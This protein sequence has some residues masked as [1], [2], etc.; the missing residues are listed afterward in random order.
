MIEKAGVAMVKTKPYRLKWKNNL[1]FLLSLI[2]YSVGLGNIWRFPYLCALN[3]GAVFLIPYAIF[4]FLVAFPLSFLELSIGQFSGKS[5]YD[6]WDI[7]PAFRGLGVAM[8]VVTG[9]LCLYYTMILAWILYYLFHSFMSPLPWTTCGNWWNTDTCFVHQY[10]TDNFTSTGGNHTNNLTS[11]LRNL[12][13]YA[14]NYSSL[15]NTNVSSTHVNISTIGLTAPE[16]FWNYNV[17]RM[18]TGLD[19]LGSMQWQLVVPLIISWIIIFLCIIKGVKSAGKVVYLT[20]IAPYIIITIILIRAATLPGAIDGVK[21]YIIPDFSKLANP[22]MWVQALMQIFYSAGMGWGG[23]ITMSSYNKFD[24]NVMRDTIIFCIVGEGTSF[25]AGFVVFSIL[26]FMSHQTGLDIA[27]IIRTGPGLA[28]IAYPEALSQLPIPQLWAVLFFLMLV[29]AA[30]DSMF[31]NV[32]VC[33]TAITDLIPKSTPKLRLMITAV[34]CFLMCLVSLIFTSQAGIYI[35]Q[36]VDW[37]MSAVIVFLITVLEVIIIGWIYGADRYF[38]D[39]EMMLGK[40]PLFLFKILWKFINPLILSVILVFTLVQ[41]QPP[42]YG[43]YVY[44]PYASAIGW[45][46][47]LISAVPIPIWMIREFITRKGPLL[48]RIKLSFQP[49]EKWGPAKDYKLAIQSDC[50]ELQ[51]MK[52]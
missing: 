13:Q 18:S 43:D 12:V 25:Y 42:T 29:F 30:L 22:Q 32:E 6:V 28:F 46:I 21:F 14:T 7:C 17:L 8:I 33:V 31:V 37:Y 15:M 45:I 5:T 1:E 16:E 3:G 49:N 50:K 26:G 24:N 48:Q 39:M 41:Y 44:P 36:L 38:G 20:A 51:S 35:Y 47:A 40:R 11:S 10:R 19:D 34:T 23:F 2:G 27:E 52:S 4:M 9:I